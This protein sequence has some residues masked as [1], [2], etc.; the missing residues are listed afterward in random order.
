MTVKRSSI[1]VVGAARCQERPRKDDFT[2]Y[3]N[4]REASHA[5][6]LSLKRSLCADILC[7]DPMYPSSGKFEDVTYTSTNLPDMKRLAQTDRECIVL[8][9]CSCVEPLTIPGSNLLWIHL[10]NGSIAE[11][12]FD[13]M[14]VLGGNVG[15]TS[16]RDVREYCNMLHDARVYG[17]PLVE[18]ICQAMPVLQHMY[19]P[20]DVETK[21]MLTVYLASEP[22]VDL[23]VMF[24]MM[25]GAL[26]RGRDEWLTRHM[27]TCRRQ[28]IDHILCKQ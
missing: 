6:L 4:P 5:D 25:S 26:Y 13:I 2:N 22:D 14:R 18:P 8:N 12:P 11:V 28:L 27:V 23:R 16:F 9:F 7:Y 3:N 10:V 24:E 20:D 17:P 21:E 15:F 1:Y 19:W